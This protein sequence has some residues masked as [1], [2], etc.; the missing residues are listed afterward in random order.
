MSSKPDFRAALNAPGILA[1]AHRGAG[2]CAPENTT[3]AFQAAVD[4][5]YLVLETDIQA[6]KDGTC[7]AFHDNDLFR[8][9]GDKRTIGQLHDQDID[10]LRIEGSHPIPK[11]VDLF[12]TFPDTLFNLDAKTNA[13]PKPMANLILATGRVSQVC[14]GSFKDARIRS[15]LKILGPDTCHG[16]GIL[17][18]AR[19]FLAA[20]TGINPGLTADCVQLPMRQYGI[21]MITPKT[22][23]FARHLGVK[24]HVW[25]INDQATITRLTGLGVDGIMTDECRLLKR[26]LTA[27]GHWP[28]WK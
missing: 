28:A 5:G 19:F 1:F 17:N 3:A 11:L 10:K 13:T 8:L 9:T 2:D 4:M 21:D 27:Q 15:V 14:I 24:V 7:Y 26:E 16:A 20:Q 12:A 22:I 25:T 18:S 6:S 23:A